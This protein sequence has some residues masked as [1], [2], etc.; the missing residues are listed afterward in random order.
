MKDF[1]ISISWQIEAYLLS[2]SINYNHK[3]LDFPIYDSFVYTLLKYF[4]DVDRVYILKNEDLKDYVKFKNIL[5][6]LRR[7]YGL[8]RFN[9]KE[10]DKYLWLL[11][12]EKFPKNYEKSKRD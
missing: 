5:T 1:D 2:G 4:R 11:G 7:Y 10:I 3:R 12:K 9:L 6:E 8:E